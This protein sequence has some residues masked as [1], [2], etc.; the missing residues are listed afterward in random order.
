MM[1]NTEK[2]SLIADYNQ[3]E[4]LLIRDT[5]KVKQKLRDFIK[6][7]G[8]DNLCIL[9]DFDYTLTRYSLDGVSKLDASFACIRNVSTFNLQLSHH[10]RT[11]F[12]SI[13]LYSNIL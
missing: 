11:T 9:S 2:R 7:G 12:P 5:Q 10:L 4:V 13:F 3:D 1:K 8:L 6:K